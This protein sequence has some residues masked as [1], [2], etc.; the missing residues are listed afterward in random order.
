MNVYVEPLTGVEPEC[1]DCRFFQRDSTC[2]MFRSVA[3]KITW[4]EQAL[5]LLWVFE[6]VMDELEIYDVNA[7]SDVHNLATASASSC[8]IAS[9]VCVT[10]KFIG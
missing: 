7:S 6:R 4:M 8:A 9:G 5:E 2:D 10:E 3:L 1:F